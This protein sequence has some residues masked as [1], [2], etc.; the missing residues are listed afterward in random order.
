MPQLIRK[1]IYLQSKAF[2]ARKNEEVYGKK[3]WTGAVVQSRGNW[4][5]NWRDQE[6]HVSS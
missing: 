4:P 6:A 1:A 2:R 3:T 5:S